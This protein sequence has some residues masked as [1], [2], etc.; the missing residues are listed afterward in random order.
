MEGDICNTRYRLKDKYATIVLGNELDAIK[1]KQANK[2]YKGVAKIVAK[3][4][5]KKTETELVKKLAK[6]VNSATYTKMIVDHLDLDEQDL[7][8]LC[9]KIL[10]VQQLCKVKGQ[11]TS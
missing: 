7:E 9:R 3:Y 5:I 2:Y 8:L 11:S 6:K 1:F 4:T 10:I